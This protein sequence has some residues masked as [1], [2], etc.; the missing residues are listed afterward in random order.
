VTEVASVLAVERSHI[1]EFWPDREHEEF[2]WTLGPSRATLP[3]F[4]VRRI[5]PALPSEPWTYVSV[6]AWTA[7]PGD[8]HCLE[9]FLDSPEESPLHVE[10]LA[11]VANFHADAR[12]RLKPGSILDIGRPWM[13]GANADHLLV[14]LPY[15]YGPSLEHCLVEERHVRFLWLVPVF[16]EEAELARREGVDALERLLEKTAIDVLSTT[17]SSVV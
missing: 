12:F 17:R 11:M 15:P 3:A 7:T 5:A 4:R 2:V 8:T 6:G 16:R 1:G 9:F 10:L 13:E 14:S